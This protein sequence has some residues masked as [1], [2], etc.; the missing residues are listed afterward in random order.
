MGYTE[1]GKIVRK[2]MIDHDENLLSIAQLF[3]VTTSFV[4]AVLIGSK[5]IPDNWVDVLAKHYNFSK[6]KRDELYNAYCEAKKNVRLDVEDA[7]LP[8]KKLAIQFQRKLT[9][10]SDEEMAMI[11][12]ILEG[13]DDD[14]L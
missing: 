11:N 6:E 9:G 10:L 1:F 3:D 2:A 13:G 4:S 7:S 12:N 5:S 14:G 8:Q